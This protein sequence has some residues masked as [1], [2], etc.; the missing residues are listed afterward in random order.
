[1][2]PFLEP[3]KITSVIIARRGKPDLE[4]HPEMDMTSEDDDNDLPMGMESAAEDVMRAL[5]KRSV[6]DLA[7]SL[8]AAFELYDSMPHQEGPHEEEYGED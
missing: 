4:S 2:L 7:K 5:D 6:K 1:M 8:H 3:K